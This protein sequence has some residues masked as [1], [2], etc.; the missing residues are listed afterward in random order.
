[1]M[2]MGWKFLTPIALVNIV[3]TGAALLMLKK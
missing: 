1:L 2:D 3:V